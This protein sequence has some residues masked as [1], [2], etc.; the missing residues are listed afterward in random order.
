SGNKR[1]LF[2][3]R[4]CILPGVFFL[5]VAS[6]GNTAAMLVLADID[7]GR[8]DFIFL[9][10]S[11]LQYAQALPMPRSLKQHIVRA[12]SSTMLLHGFL[13][14]TIFDDVEKKSHDLAAQ[15]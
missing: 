6:A 4:V 10:Q 12:V 1:Q 14:M 3:P 8:R 7:A 13:P 15:L 5:F 9:A 11:T 2:F